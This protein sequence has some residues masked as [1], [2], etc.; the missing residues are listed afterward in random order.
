MPRRP[1]SRHLLPGGGGVCQQGVPVGTGGESYQRLPNL[2]ST[3]NPYIATPSPQLVVSSYS[4]A[5]EACMQTQ[6]PSAECRSVQI[7]SDECCLVLMPNAECLS[8]QMTSTHQWVVPL[9]E[10]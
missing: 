1:R 4:I 2:S 6:I 7:P 5:P 10:A 9:S 3:P 8:D